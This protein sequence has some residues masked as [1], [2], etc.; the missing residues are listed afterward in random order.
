MR[1]R[2]LA[3]VVA[4]PLAVSVLACAS[5]AGSSSNN[6]GPQDPGTVTAAASEAAQAAPTGPVTAFADGTY[7]VG[8]GAG[9]VPPG[10]YKSTAVDNCYWERLKTLG[11]QFSDII[12]NDNANPGEPVIVSIAKTD[13]G[14]KTTG[15]GTWRKSG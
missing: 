10:T 15:C 3:A 14:F 2:A 4:A 5:S 8:G 1:I 7:E 13:K 12:A 9:Q 11:G 6:A